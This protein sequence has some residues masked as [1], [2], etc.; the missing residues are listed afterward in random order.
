MAASPFLDTNI[1]LRHLTQD[2]PDHSA[3]ATALLRRVAKGEITV[4]T[5][6]TVVFETVFT[7]QR[8]YRTSRADIRAVLLPLLALPCVQ[9]RGKRRYRRVFELYVSLPALS[10]ADCY[11]VALVESRSV[12]EIVS[13]DQELSRVRTVTRVEPDAQG[14]LGRR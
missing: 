7:L 4:D 5:G 14:E 12:R 1:L 8:F 6:D 11:H 2:H 9:L 3:R 10:F 13:F